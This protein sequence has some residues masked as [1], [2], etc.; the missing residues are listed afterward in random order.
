M[1]Q[2]VMVDIIEQHQKEQNRL[3]HSVKKPEENLQNLFS[4]SPKQQR[5]SLSHSCVLQQQ[6][7]VF[8]HKLQNRLLSDERK[9]IQEKRSHKTF[10]P[11]WCIGK[12]SQRD[13]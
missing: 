13:C 8:A 7:H 10:L 3:S 9:A 5:D 6:L 1:T 12:Q 4:L 2:Q 11:A